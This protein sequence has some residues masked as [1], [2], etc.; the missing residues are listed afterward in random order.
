MTM[1]VA[2][3]K[4]SETIPKMLSLVA[5]LHRDVQ[6]ETRPAWYAITTS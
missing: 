6:G 2:D 3:Q 5:V 1:T 4:I